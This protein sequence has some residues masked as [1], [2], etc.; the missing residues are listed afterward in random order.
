[1]VTIG[2]H[3]DGEAGPVFWERENGPKH[4]AA[5]SEAA[6]GIT[7]ALPRILELHRRFEI[8]ATFFIPAHIAER[9]P[10]MVEAIVADGHE[11]GHHGY[12]HENVFALSAA[13]ER[14]IFEHANEILL[15][16]TGRTPKGWSAP[17]W[18]VTAQ[19]LQIMAELGLIYDGSL[20]DYDRPYFVGTAAGELIELPISMVLDDW[21]MFGGGI[22]PYSA[23]QIMPADQARQIW[24]EEF[25]GLRQ[26]GGLF[27]STFH[28]NLTGR[29]GR[30]LKLAELF[31][32]MRSFDDVWW[33]TCEKAAAW[34]LTFDTP[35]ASAAK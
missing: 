4:L 17:G 35:G 33:G 6:Y 26:Y 22:F 2:W 12:M 16:L 5:M 27:H 15:G 8:P 3:V 34:M 25:A 1:G 10:Q 11:I 14:A 24:Q 30:L 32:Y 7:T 21:A 9:Y 19:T 20:M 23:A 29:P 13:D 18:G 28:P 31:Q